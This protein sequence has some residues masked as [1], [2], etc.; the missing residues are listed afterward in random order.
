MMRKITLSLVALAA[1]PV[2]GKEVSLEKDLMPLFQRSC[3]TCHA[4]DSGVRGAIKDGTFFDTKKDIMDKVGT[5]IIPGK[6]EE[7]GLLKVLDQTKKFGKR[8]IPM[9]PPKSG[10]P[11]WSEEEIAEITAWI[12][13]GAKNN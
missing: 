6:P 4:P 3:A 5:F 9:P 1:L 13:A 11:K 7:S 10:D 12:K 8:N 2:L